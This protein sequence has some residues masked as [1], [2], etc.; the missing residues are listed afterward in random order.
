M[1][2]YNSLPFHRHILQYIMHVFTARAPSHA[3]T[4]FP[5]CASVSTRRRPSA[6]S[7]PRFLPACSH[8]TLVALACVALLITV[9]A[10]VPHRSLFCTLQRRFSYLYISVLVLLGEIFYVRYLSDVYLFISL[11]NV[12]SEILVTVFFCI[13][14]DVHLRVEEPH[15]TMYTTYHQIRLWYTNIFA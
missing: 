10:L 8:A 15:F 2:Y 7:S 5:T 11:N 12:Y 13:Y 9:I 1:S 14:R 3:H 4:V 6:K